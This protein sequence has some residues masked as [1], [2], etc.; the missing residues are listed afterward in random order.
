MLNHT[1]SHFGSILILLT[2]LGIPQVRGIFFSKITASKTQKQK[3]A[4]VFDDLVHIDAFHHLV[5]DWNGSSTHIIFHMFSCPSVEIDRLGGDT[6]LF[7]HLNSGCDKR[8]RTR[9]CLANIILEEMRQL[10]KDL[11]NVWKTNIH[12]CFCC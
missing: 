9:C 10:E 4:G 5:G 7:I 6:L 12:V 2:T 8:V 1:T 11:G 3:L